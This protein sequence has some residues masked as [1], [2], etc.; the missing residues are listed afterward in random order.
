MKHILS[1]IAGFTLVTIAMPFIALSIIIETI[2]T[3]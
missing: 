3:M 2:W 1:G